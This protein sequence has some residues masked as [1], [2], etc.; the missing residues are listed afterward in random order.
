MCN[1]L[2]SCPTTL[3]VPA[4]VNPSVLFENHAIRHYN[5][6]KKFIFPCTKVCERKKKK[7]KSPNILAKICNICLKIR[8]FQFWNATVVPDGN[9]GP[10]AL[11][12]AHPSYFIGLHFSWC[13]IVSPFGE[14]WPAPWQW[15]LLWC[16][17]RDPNPLW[18]MGSLVAQTTVHM[19]PH[20]S[21]LESK[22][23]FDFLLK[24]VGLGCWIV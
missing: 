11:H 3:Y 13:T 2:Q 19:R 8:L 16:M 4:S 21:I 7:R 9:H 1:I 24:H 12:N 14:R 18:R 20:R 5:S 10:D 22:P 23:H 17:H 6:L 15:R